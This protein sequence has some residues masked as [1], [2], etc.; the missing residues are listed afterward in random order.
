MN[1]IKIGNKKIGPKQTVKFTASADMIEKHFT[2]NPKLRQSDNFVSVTKDEVIEI[3]FNIN[4][5][6]K[7]MGSGEIEKIET[8]DFMWNFRRDT[9]N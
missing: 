9:R 7:Y 5:V 6:R 4:K 1:E 3:K 2:I 8:E